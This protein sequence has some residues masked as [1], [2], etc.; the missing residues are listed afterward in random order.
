MDG[1]N[2]N[3]NNINNNNFYNNNNNNNNNNNKRVRIGLC[4]G[5]LSSV[6]VGEEGLYCYCC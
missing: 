3:S 1:N 6:Q 4:S 5:Y 2:N